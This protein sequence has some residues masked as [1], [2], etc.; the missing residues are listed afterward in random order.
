MTFM[1]E[2]MTSAANE[3][4]V[5]A[6]GMNANTLVPDTFMQFAATTSLNRATARSAPMPPGLRLAANAP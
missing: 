3:A 4:G 5:A 1:L 2:T 6:D